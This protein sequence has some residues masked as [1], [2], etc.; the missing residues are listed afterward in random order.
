MSS[1]LFIVNKRVHEVARGRASRRAVNCGII[2]DGR[3]YAY[4]HER[5]R[6]RSRRNANDC[7]RSRAK[8][9]PPRSGRDA[10]LRRDERG[11]EDVAKIKAKQGKV[12]G[13]W[14]RG[15]TAARRRAETFFRSTREC[16]TESRLVSHRALGGSRRL[17]HR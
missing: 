4:I 17:R 8:S 14:W 7:R 10:H 16:E 12:H 13:E 2:A 3:S 11:A 6:E 5:E 1:L 15:E 9:S